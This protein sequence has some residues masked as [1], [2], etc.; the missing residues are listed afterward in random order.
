MLSAHRVKQGTR[1][2]SGDETILHGWGLGAGYNL[3]DPL[4]SPS[5]ECEPLHDAE[6]IA[7]SFQLEQSALAEQ[8]CNG[9]SARSATLDLRLLAGQLAEICSRNF[10]HLL[11]SA[12]I[13]IHRAQRHQSRI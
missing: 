5:G 6:A 1:S 3:I 11:A 2:I 12:P 10:H 13:C 8:D 9:I 4:Y 7:P